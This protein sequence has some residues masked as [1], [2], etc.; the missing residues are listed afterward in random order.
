MNDTL[1]YILNKYKINLGRQYI[2]DIPNMGRDQLAGLFAELKFTK[3]AEIGVESGLYSETLLKANPKLFLTSID[4]WEAS[5]YE[6]GIVGIDYRQ[7]YFNQCYRTAKKRLAPYNCQV[8]RKTS[9][10]AVDN[11]KDNSLDFVYI[12]GGHDFVNVANDIHYWLKKVRPGG[13]LS[14][15]DYAFFP[16]GKQ[17]HVKYIVPNY[18]RAYGIIPLFIVGAEAVGRRG[19]IRDK[20]RSWFWV[21]A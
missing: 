19:V 3:G 11:F 20:F 17:N 9:M 1:K 8:V 18:T 2:V 6:P 16:G 13:I 5:A 21:K 7:Q 10:E 4:P 12:D 15:H 14:G